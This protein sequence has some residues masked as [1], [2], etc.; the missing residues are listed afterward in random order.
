[1]TKSLQQK[2]KLLEFIEN[3]KDFYKNMQGI[4]ITS[5]EDIQ[6]AKD[7]YSYVSNELKE[8]ENIR[9]ELTSPYVQFCRKVNT[10]AKQ[11]SEFLDKG[12]SLINNKVITFRAE[13]KK[14]IEALQEK[15]LSKLISFDNFEET[16]QIQSK[17]VKDE[18]GLKTKWLMT[19]LTFEVTDESKVPREYLIVD[20]RKIRQA[21]RE[22]KKVKIDGV[23]IYEK[24]TLTNK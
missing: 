17:L 6:A 10:L 2:D 20:D 15:V 19:R 9:K 13:E 4:T 18:E 1:M 8:I 12:K 23:R 5:S 14:R 3:W 7:K 22:D 16:A 11:A 21:I 24:E